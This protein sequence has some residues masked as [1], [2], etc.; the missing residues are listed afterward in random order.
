MTV[1]LDYQKSMVDH[2]QAE[3]Q[4]VQTFELDT[5]HCPNLTKTKEVVEIV[6]QIV[7]GHSR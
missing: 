7:S 2:M 3:G 6:K 1:P 4:E 5:G